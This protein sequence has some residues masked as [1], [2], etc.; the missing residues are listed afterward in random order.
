MQHYL[1]NKHNFCKTAMK[2]AYLQSNVNKDGT[3]MPSALGDFGYTPR[4]V[5]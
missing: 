4:M 5:R 1:E 2:S 3:M